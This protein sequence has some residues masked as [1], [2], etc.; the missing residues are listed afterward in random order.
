MAET[1]AMPLLTPLACT[2]FST[3]GVMCTYSRCFLVLKV[4]YSVWNFIF[5]RPIFFV[6]SVNEMRRMGW[7]GKPRHCKQAALRDYCWLICMVWSMLMVLGI[8]EFSG[9]E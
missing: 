3:C 6:S 4:R 5:A 9:P 8:P 1:S 2:I 7:A